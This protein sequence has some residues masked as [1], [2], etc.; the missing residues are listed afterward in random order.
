[1]SS[2]PFIDP[3]T[4]AA[5]QAQS[6]P[7]SALGG[8]PPPQMPQPQAPP[9][10]AV[11]APPPPND[12]P[13]P[14]T[15]GSAPTKPGPL[16]HLLTS[17]LYGAGQ[18]AMHHAGLQ[19]DP[20][21]QAQQAQIANTTATTQALNDQRAA[22]L[23]ETQRKAQ[24]FVIP[25]SEDVPPS[26]R[27]L[28]TTVGGYEALAPLF[29]RQQTAQGVADTRAEAA[30]TV[31]DT[32]AGGR[33]TAAKI[34]AQARREVAQGQ[35]SL[36]G[37]R[38]AIS[39]AG[40][41]LRQENTEA[42]LF[43]TVGGRPV[44]NAPMIPQADGTLRVGGLRGAPNAEAQQGKVISFNDLQGSAEHAMNA[45]NALHATGAD[46]SDAKVIAAMHD[47]STAAGKYINGKFIKPS[48]STQQIEAIN[49]LNQ[50]R[51][52]A[53]IMRTLTKGTGAEAQ[54]QRV[55]DTLPTAGDSKAT[56]VD[57]MRQMQLVMGRLAPGVSGVAA[58]AQVKTPS[59]Q[60]VRK[61]NP[62]TGRL[63]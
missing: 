35:L 57:K 50:L 54:A 59:T 15:Q 23:A 53:G 42:N 46:L 11:P 43:G 63:E 56:A 44:P 51:E 48:L 4:L 6:S 47:P 61:F 26:L 21:A 2:I 55:L 62:Q 30:T 10:Q 25:S 33:V 5:L 8:A 31:A 12:V 34:G 24:P 29:V 1:M 39:R 28:R 22:V 58:G 13:S 9:P 7:L 40:L 38:L 49:S 20:E 32:N 18:A 3:Q 19:T 52:Q 37:Q 16:K 27:G 17:F 60:T 45:L 36:A 41:G 14:A